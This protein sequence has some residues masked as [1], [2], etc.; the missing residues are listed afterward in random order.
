MHNA[1]WGLSS[2]TAPQP[3]YAHEISS[4]HGIKHKGASIRSSDIDRKV[5]AMLQNGTSHYV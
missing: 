3:E 2:D 1:S 4:S 5:L